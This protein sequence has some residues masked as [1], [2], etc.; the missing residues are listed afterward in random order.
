MKKTIATLLAAL[1]AL[2]LS[3]AAQAVDVPS[4]RGADIMSPDKDPAKHQLMVVSGGIE[5]NYKEQPPMVPH[6]VEKYELNVRVNGCLKCHGPE[7]YEKEKSPKIGDSHFLDRDGKKL[8]QVSSRR[9]FCTQCHVPQLSG[10]P[11]VDNSFKGRK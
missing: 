6:E 2:T 11:L 1:A 9:W 3:A 5:R 4:L 8:D 10:D 7:S